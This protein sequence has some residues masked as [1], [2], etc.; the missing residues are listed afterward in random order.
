VNNPYTR[1]QN[2]LFFLCDVLRLAYLVLNKVNFLPTFRSA[3]WQLVCMADR[4][5]LNNLLSR[6]T[7]RIGARDRD[8]SN[9]FVC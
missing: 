1:K 2:A 9:D 6:T 4:F 7:S 3:A 5:E 8:L